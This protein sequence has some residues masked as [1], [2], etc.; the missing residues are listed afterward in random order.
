VQLDCKLVNFEFVN[1]RFWKD[2]LEFNG[3]DLTK[4]L[5][6]WSS[7]SQVELVDNV[8]TSLKVGEDGKR[9]RD[10]KSLFAFDLLFNRNVD[11]FD[12]A[13]GEFLFI[14]EGQVASLLPWPES[15]IDDFN[16]FDKGCSWASRKD[17]FWFFLEDCSLIVPGM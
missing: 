12:R 6:F 7:E 8:F 11:D 1:L 10:C 5:A 16:L 3:N 9:D 4:W 15:L 2:H 14:M 17:T 13:F